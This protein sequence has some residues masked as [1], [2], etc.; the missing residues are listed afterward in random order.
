MFYFCVQKA[1]DSVL[2]ASTTLAVSSLLLR[3]LNFR[4]EKFFLIDTR[5]Q[6]VSPGTR[7]VFCMKIVGFVFFVSFCVGFLANNQF[8]VQ[9]S[10]ETKKNDILFQLLL[11]FILNFFK[12][13]NTKATFERL[14][15]P[16][17]CPGN[18]F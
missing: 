16:G 17:R 13:L 14:I 5:G 3:G 10:K 4:P 9:K 12:T 6:N 2:F 15:V 1:L 8:K 7:C 11:I 18:F